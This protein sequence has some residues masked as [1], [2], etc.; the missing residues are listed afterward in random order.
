MRL[1]EK[2]RTAIKKALHK[3]FESTARAYLFGSRIDDQK[4]G[5]DID[6]L[7][8][9]RLQGEELIVAKLRAMSDVQLAI[10]DRKIDIVT[11]SPDCT[12]GQ[13]LIIQNARNQGIAL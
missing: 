13:P 9:T 11:I 5:G 4:R 2:E 6:L 7:I 10:G 1:S 12:T 3:H 8:E